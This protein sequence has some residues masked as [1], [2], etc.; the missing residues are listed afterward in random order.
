MADLWQWFMA[1]DTDRSGSIGPQELQR[2]L[3]M[4]GLNYS[5]AMCAQM[6]RWVALPA[7][8]A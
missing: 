3:A 2:A 5:L 4:G 1:V 6:I 8:P 7:S